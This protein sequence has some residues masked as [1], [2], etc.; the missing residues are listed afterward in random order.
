VRLSAWS[1]PK[2]CFMENVGLC[3]LLIIGRP[4][5][6][7]RYENTIVRLEAARTLISCRIKD[8][9]STSA[10]R[11]A[12]MWTHRACRRRKV[13][14]RVICSRIENVYRL[15]DNA[16]LYWQGTYVIASTD[17]R[18]RTN[19]LSLGCGNRSLSVNIV[20]DCNRLVQEWGRGDSVALS[21]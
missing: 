10:W 16:Y 19:E 8:E 17:A 13:Q 12:E 7:D 6:D 1:I 20:S 3:P 15:R 4:H 5:R 9:V 21:R 18:Y 11:K 14:T 2:P